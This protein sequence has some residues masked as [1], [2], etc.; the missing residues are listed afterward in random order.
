MKGKN[1]Y[2]GHF[3]HG[4][5]LAKYHS[6][7]IIRPNSFLRNTKRITTMTNFFPLTACK[8]RPSSPHFLINSLKLIEEIFCS[9]PSLPPSLTGSEL[10]SG[11]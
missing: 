8:G 5:L 2:K 7:G 10:L 4:S 1:K 6:N 11:C 3:L 9:P